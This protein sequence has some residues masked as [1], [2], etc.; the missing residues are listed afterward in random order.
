MV[1]EFVNGVNLEQFLERHRALDRAVPVDFA[2]FIASRVARG[3]D[4]RPP[5]DA[6]ARATTS[7]SCTATSTRRTSC[8]PT[9]A[10]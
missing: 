10:T 3:P 5:E 9:R 8:S 7:T 1:M 6:T 2:V 4:L